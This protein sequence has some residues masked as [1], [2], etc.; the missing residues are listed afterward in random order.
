MQDPTG[1]AIP[2]LLAA[3]ETIGGLYCHNYAS[4]NGLIPPHRRQKRGGVCKDKVAP[5]RARIRARM[6]A[7][8]AEGLIFQSI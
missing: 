5:I 2:S 6:S 4:G 7:S 3:G 1:A 8:P